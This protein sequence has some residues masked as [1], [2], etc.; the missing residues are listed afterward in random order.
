MGPATFLQEQ[1]GF[2][3]NEGHARRKVGGPSGRLKAQVWATRTSLLQRAM[4]DAAALH[5]GSP[6]KM[7][8]VAN[9][10]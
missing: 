10:L 7:A 9:D 1:L 5:V 2:A 6:S 8:R 3:N 4:G